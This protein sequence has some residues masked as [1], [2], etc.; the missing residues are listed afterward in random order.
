M[1]EYTFDNPDYK[2]R[3]RPPHLTFWRR[4]LSVLYPEIKLA[5]GPAIEDGF[6][7]HFDS[8]EPITAEIL[9]ELEAEMKKII[10]EKLPLERFELPREEAIKLMEEKTSL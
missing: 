4:P 2:L 3:Y 8:P 5:I 7:L 6:Y 10:K 9:A 1:S